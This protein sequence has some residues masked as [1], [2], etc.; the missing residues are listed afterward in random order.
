MAQTRNG[1]VTSAEPSRPLTIADAR[2]CQ[3]VGQESRATGFWGAYVGRSEQ[4]RGP[5]A[6]RA[7]Y[8]KPHLMPANHVKAAKLVRSNAASREGAQRARFLQK[9]NTLLIAAAY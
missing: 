5:E 9:S 4:R 3:T 1:T 7:R 2:A 6:I 8:A